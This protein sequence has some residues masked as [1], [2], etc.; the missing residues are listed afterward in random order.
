ML[1]L[2]A[3]PFPKNKTGHRTHWS[4]VAGCATSSI[5]PKRPLLRRTEFSASTCSL[6]C[7]YY[8]YILY[9]V[10]CIGPVQG[11]DGLFHKSVLMHLPLFA[12]ERYRVTFSFDHASEPH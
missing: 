1:P 2:L 9:L 5:C 7:F 11:V 6:F 10:V 12:G 4:L 3:V 8:Y